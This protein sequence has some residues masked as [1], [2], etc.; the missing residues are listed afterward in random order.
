VYSSEV[1]G[2]VDVDQNPAITVSITPP[3]GFVAAV[4]SQVTFTY[5]ITNSGNVT[6][7]SPY[8]IIEQ[9]MTETATCPSASSLAPLATTT[10]TLVH[11]ITNAEMTSG[12]I[13][14]T[15]NATAYH[16]ADVITSPQATVKVATYNGPRLTLEIA[17][18]PGSFPSAGTALSITFTLRNTGNTVL[19]APYS[20]SGNAFLGTITCSGLPATL[21]LGD[22]TTCT[23]SYTTTSADRDAGKVVVN[24]TGTAQDGG[25]PLNSDSVTH[26]IPS[27][28]ECWVYHRVGGVPDPSV[29][30]HGTPRRQISMTVYSDALT[31]DTITIANVELINWDQASNYISSITFGGSTVW[32]GNSGAVDPFSTAVTLGTRTLSSGASKVLTFFANA[33]LAATPIPQIKV[34]FAEPGCPVLDTA[35]SSQVKP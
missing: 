22:E 28:F 34:T 27:S 3:S 35:D 16:G 2:S 8:G 23:A 25:S 9:G 31:T 26:E 32:T 18:T 14:S 20:V 6:L 24:A 30:V 12:M 19:S 17:S 21:A 29:S 7:S 10:C 4:G 1:I 13:T 33:N 11:T 5:T 15:A